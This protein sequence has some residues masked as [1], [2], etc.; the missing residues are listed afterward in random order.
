MPQEM[1]PLA[2]R[3]PRLAVLCLALAGCASPPPAAYRVTVPR[4]TFEADFDA[5]EAAVAEARAA[6][7]A[8]GFFT[9]ALLGAAYGAAIGAEHGHTGTH[10]A[11]GAGLG[12]LVGLVRG[13][14][15]ADDASVGDCMRAKGY[16][17]A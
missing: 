15:W 10:A 16:R 3:A 6:N 5:C 13:V 9:G 17:R 2:R 7:G 12:A 14:R 11:V 1:T 4:A 8:E